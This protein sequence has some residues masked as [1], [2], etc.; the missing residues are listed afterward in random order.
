MMRKTATIINLWNVR[1]CLHFFDHHKISVLPKSL[2]QTVLHIQYN[3]I[4]FRLHVIKI[5]RSLIY[6]LSFLLCQM[7]ELKRENGLS[8]AQ[9]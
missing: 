9:Q 5:N 3:D 1:T 4:A 2:Y 7:Y 6:S 8:T